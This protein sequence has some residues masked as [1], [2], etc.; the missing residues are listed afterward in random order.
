MSLFPDLQRNFE[1]ANRIY[2]L[3]RNVFSGALQK[4][5]TIDNTIRYDTV[6]YGA[7]RYG[8]R[9]SRYR[10]RA[11]WR[12][13]GPDFALINPPFWMLRTLFLQQKNP[14]AS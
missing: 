10:M 7:V 5:C 9:I 3:H 4:L 8:H 12:I 2:T 1:V 13:R 6:R 11:W 14:G